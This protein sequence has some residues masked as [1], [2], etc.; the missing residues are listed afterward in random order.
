M[1][2]RINDRP[3]VVVSPTGRASVR[4]D[5]LY[6]DGE[7]VTSFGAGDP[8]QPQPLPAG[9]R[10]AGVQGSRF[11]DRSGNELYVL[12]GRK[13]EIA[14]GHVRINGKS[15]GHEPYVR[16]TARYAKGPLRL[17]PNQYYVLGDNRN[18]SADSHM[19]GALDGGRIVGRVRS[20]YWP[21]ARA[22]RVNG[23]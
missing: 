8:P 12:R 10:Q 7:I 4:K 3:V 18:N 11:T 20:R 16:E 1:H 15:L 14:P 23:N 22:G 5:A 6:A 2:L 17:G 21:P 19:W 9:F 13:I